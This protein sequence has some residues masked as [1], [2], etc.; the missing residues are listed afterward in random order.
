MKLSR[1]LVS[2]KNIKVLSD[3]EFKMSIRRN[4]HFNEIKCILLKNTYVK[5]D[6]Q[7]KSLEEK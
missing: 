5:T 6:V 7:T 4:V 2:M 3:G 1:E